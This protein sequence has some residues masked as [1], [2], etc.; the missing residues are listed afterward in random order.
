MNVFE[1]KA[2]IVHAMKAGNAP[3]Q[4]SAAALDPKVF[5]TN[6][7]QTAADALRKAV[8]SLLWPKTLHN[9]RMNFPPK[10]SIVTW[11]WSLQ[12]LA[13]LHKQKA[14]HPGKSVRAIVMAA[15]VDR[16]RSEARRT[17]AGAKSQ[18]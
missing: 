11:R 13:R 16:V 2:L 18:R 10:Q 12:P 3:L 4:P 14:A 1:T 7:D 9:Y 5:A 6:V 15:N 8:L 17:L